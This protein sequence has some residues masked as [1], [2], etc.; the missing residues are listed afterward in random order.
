M[1]AGAEATIMPWRRLALSLARWAESLI[2]FGIFHAS[3]MP[4][5]HD[6]FDPLARRLH[7]PRPG[8]SPEEREC[9][10]PRRVGSGLFAPQRLAPD[11]GRQAGAAGRSA[12]E[13]SRFGRRQLRLRRY[14]W[15]QRP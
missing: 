5:L 14:Q 1:A 3:P 2:V 13:Y 15:L 6:L 9:H 11:T 7:R 8:S 12:A 10:V 4:V